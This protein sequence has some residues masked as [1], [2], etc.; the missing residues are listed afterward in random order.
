MEALLGV[1]KYNPIVHDVLDKER[2]KGH[3]LTPFEWMS[4]ESVAETN[5]MKYHLSNFLELKNK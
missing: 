4:I 1:D 2:A 5:H 3:K